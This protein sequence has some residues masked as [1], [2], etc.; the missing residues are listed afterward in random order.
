M[1]Q[2]IIETRIPSSTFLA[3]DFGQTTD[4]KSQLIQYINNI[5]RHRK[6][7]NNIDE[8]LIV[9]K[10]G[11]LTG[12]ISNSQYD[13]AVALIE[14]GCFGNNINET[15]A[16]CR[17]IDTANIDEQHVKVL[18]A[19]MQAVKNKSGFLHGFKV[20]L[21][22]RK[23]L[24]THPLSQET[25][26]QLLGIIGRLVKI[27]EGS[28][29]DNGIKLT[30]EYARILDSTTQ[31]Q[32]APTRDLIA[33]DRFLNSA[34]H[35]KGDCIEGYDRYYNDM[36][37]AIFSELQSKIPEQARRGGNAIDVLVTFDRYL[38]SRFEEVKDGGAVMKLVTKL[39]NDKFKND[40]TEFTIDELRYYHGPE[41]ARYVLVAS[42]RM[43]S[44]PP[45]KT[46]ISKIIVYSGI[47][48]KDG[49]SC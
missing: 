48:I 30:H 43:G 24:K 33:A 9:N 25:A 12:D 20:D 47:T 13:L 8:S 32:P 14:N 37:K 26:G 44:I 2:N 28:A 7:R 1:E 16:L 42:W 23:T 6:L 4:K 18:T 11:K 3:Y 22:F 21:A 19:L 38:L 10:L 17:V 39:L 36:A 40:K 29:V 41:G 5:E 34:V 45:A 15:A 46:P 49:P 27:T 31:S 35:K